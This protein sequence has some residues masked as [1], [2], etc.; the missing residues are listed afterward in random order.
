MAQESVAAPPTVEYELDSADELPLEAESVDY[1]SVLA[2]ADR[3]SP[4]QEANLKTAK[5]VDLGTK[6]NGGR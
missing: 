5:V 4:Q 3:R 1:G 2:A 6:R